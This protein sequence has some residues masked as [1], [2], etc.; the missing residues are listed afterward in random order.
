MNIVYLT[1]I[2][3]LNITNRN[4]LEYMRD[5][6]KPEFE[7]I[8]PT[9]LLPKE[10]LEWARSNNMPSNA[11][12]I[13]IEKRIELIIDALKNKLS[14]PNFDVLDTK[15]ISDTIQNS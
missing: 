12:D 10:V 6:D 9:H 7:A 4:P 3:N 11:L 1:Q 2:T 5:Y 15:Q 8:M 14:I 13:F